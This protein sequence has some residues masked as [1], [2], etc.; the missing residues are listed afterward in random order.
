MT[1]VERVSLAILIPTAA[2]CLWALAWIGL[3]F[4]HLAKDHL[5]K[6]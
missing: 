1:T 5:I 4:T 3:T 2:I 6:K